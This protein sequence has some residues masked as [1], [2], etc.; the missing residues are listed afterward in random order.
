MRATPLAV[1][2]LALGCSSSDSPPAEVVD[3]AVVD[4]GG[5]DVTTDTS[6][7]ETAA[8]TSGDTGPKTCASPLDCGDASLFICDLATHTC[9]PPTC[10]TKTKPCPS[11]STCAP[12]VAGVTI[13]VCAKRC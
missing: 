7:P 3:T 13:G 4:T 1:F 11:G 8:E 6:L 2:V 9:Q 5:S 12:Q 10:D